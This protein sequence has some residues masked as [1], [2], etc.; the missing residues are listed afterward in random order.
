MV[1][2]SQEDYESGKKLK[3]DLLYQMLKLTVKLTINKSMGNSLAVQQSGPHTLTAE[4]LCWIPGRVIKIPQAT[5]HGQK[6]PKNKTSMVLA[7]YKIECRTDPNKEHDIQQ[8]EHF[9]S[10]GKCC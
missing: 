7:L 10:L 8:G 3:W 2:I 6:K 1:E 9:N 4:G 5:Q